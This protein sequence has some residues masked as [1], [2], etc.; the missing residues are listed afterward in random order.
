MTRRLKRRDT[1]PRSSIDG[2]FWAARQQC[3]RRRT[4]WPAG[5][6]LRDR[7][8]GF[9]A[10]KIACTDGRPLWCKRSRQWVKLLGR[11]HAVERV[12]QATVLDAIGHG[13]V[14]WLRGR[15]LGSVERHINNLLEPINEATYDTLHR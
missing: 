3:Y 7:A 15:S 9:V 5:F 2:V 12:V 4:V 10:V 11:N 1:A 13:R 6:P 14:F 8:V